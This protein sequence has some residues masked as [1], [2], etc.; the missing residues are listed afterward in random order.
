MGGLCLER[1]GE[2]GWRMENNSKRQELELLIE[3]IV[4]DTCGK[5][6][7]ENMKKR[8]DKNHGPSHP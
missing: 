5:V 7:E 4:R 6:G 8:H 2:S 3:N 1:S